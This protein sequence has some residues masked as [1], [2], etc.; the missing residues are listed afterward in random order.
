MVNVLFCS[1]RDR[2]T[3]KRTNLMLDFTENKHFSLSKKEKLFIDLLQYKIRDLE[4]HM[5]IM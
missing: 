3:T 1:K 2:N 5:I 4:E